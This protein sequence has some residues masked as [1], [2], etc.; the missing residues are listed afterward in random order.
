MTEKDLLSALSNVDEGYIEHAATALEGRG[1]FRNRRILRTAIALAA[2][3]CLL[4]AGTVG[5]ALSVREPDGTATPH[6]PTAPDAHY[7]PLLDHTI[8]PEGITGKQFAQIGAFPGSPHA[9]AD[10][11]DVDYA[12]E[13]GIVISARVIEVLPDTYRLLSYD[14]SQ[15]HIL[16]LSVNDT[17]TGTNLPKE[18][19]YL[20]P[21]ELSTDLMNYTDI[22]F[23]MNQVG[24]DGYLIFN[25]TQSRLEAFSLLFC[26]KFVYNAGNGPV[27]AYTDQ[28][29]DEGLWDKEGWAQYKEQMQNRLD[30]DNY[31]KFPVKRTQSLEGAKAS[32]R[33]YSNAPDQRVSTLADFSSDAAKEAIA[34]AKPFVNGAFRQDV[35]YE[36]QLVYIR[37]INGFDT[38]ETIHLNGETGE[39]T[40]SDERYTAEDLQKIPDIGTLIGQLEGE[41]LLPPHLDTEGLTQMGAQISGWYRKA[42]GKVYG[43][44]KI[45]WV[46]TEKPTYQAL[47]YR[48]AAYYLAA[49]NGTYRS[50]EP[51]ELREIIGEDRRVVEYKP[52]VPIPVPMP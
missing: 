5:V 39:V 36:K 23:A 40:Y 49:S 14:P 28:T 13:Y 42:D 3:L 38:G 19:Y 12:Y 44:V 17:I 2:A 47:Q 6:N 43:I 29:V 24:R 50:I 26:A 30:P 46:Y 9:A 37:T 45:E 33:A 20:L 27:I 48:D 11:R 35:L 1:G 7:L 16:R 21:A 25:E 34:Y 32:I 8:S 31:P 52:N 4:I 41:P 51:D 15:Y 18:L 22:L 10:L